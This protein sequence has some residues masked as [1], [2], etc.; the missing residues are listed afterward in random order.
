[1][2]ENEAEESDCNFVGFIIKVVIFTVSYSI[3]SVAA[4]GRKQK[5]RDNR[6]KHGWF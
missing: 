5:E 1:M 3:L 4:P 6:K 2:C